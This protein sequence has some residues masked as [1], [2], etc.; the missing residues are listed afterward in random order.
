MFFSVTDIGP[1]KLRGWAFWFEITVPP[2]VQNI[3]ID[4]TVAGRRFWM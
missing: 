1:N 2:N 4:V 3:D